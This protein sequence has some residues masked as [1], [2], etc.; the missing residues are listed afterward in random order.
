M[1]TLGLPVHNEMY[2]FKKINT[3]SKF[4]LNKL[5]DLNGG[6]NSGNRYS[7]HYTKLTEY[8][9]ADNYTITRDHQ[10]LNLKAPKSLNN[11]NLDLISY[12]H[13]NTNLSLTTKP[14]PQENYNLSS[15][16]DL[17][18]SNPYKINPNY[19]NKLHAG[20]QFNLKLNDESLVLSDKFLS[21]LIESKPLKSP[22]LIINGLNIN[23]TY[24]TL[25][26]LKY[27]VT[28]L[29]LLTSKSLKF[30]DSNPIKSNNSYFKALN[31][32]N[33]LNSPL[34]NQPFLLTGKEQF[35]PSIYLT[36]HS[37]THYNST[38][39]S[40]RI[41]N[42]DNV[43]NLFSTQNT[44]IFDLY[45]DNSA[46]RWQLIDLYEDYFWD[47]TVGNYSLNDYSTV[48]KNIDALNTVNKLNSHYNS[49]YK[50]NLNTT[51]NALNYNLNVIYQD[52]NLNKHGMNTSLF[53]TLYNSTVLQNALDDNVLAIKSLKAINQNVNTLFTG[54]YTKLFNSIHSLTERYKY[55]Y[56]SNGIYNL[57][58]SG[59]NASTVGV[60]SVN[61]V[62][63]TYKNTSQ[64]DSIESVK[65]LNS[66]Y[67][68]LQKVY[69]TRFDENRSTTQLNGISSIDVRVPL[70]SVEK[71]NLLYNIFKNNNSYTKFAFS[72][73]DLNVNQMNNLNTN[74]NTITYDLPFLISVQSDASRYI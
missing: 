32:D 59:V 33:T 71:P 53:T 57:P 8:S 42:V 48:F 28:D 31:Y 21:N 74:L 52:F 40:A 50:L 16:N 67:L 72:I 5:N 60:T 14:S 51:L 24:R 3:I 11:L 22:Q 35:I 19:F 69:R 38:P 9:N 65:N 73:N 62:K 47:A 13:V 49:N 30:D 2:A 46:K 18:Y 68:A 25:T 6:L 10:L 55:N 45:A 4:Q 27:N 17:L 34:G 56:E 7:T 66:Y 36:A 12:K 20:M 43:L 1:Y 23:T 54:N 41:D 39:L 29:V 61:N 58:L 70:L 37:K 64:I 63:N 26:T 44:P 15:V